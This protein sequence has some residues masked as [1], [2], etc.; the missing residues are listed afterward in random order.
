M[1]HLFEPLFALIY[2]FDCQR[3]KLPRIPDRQCGTPK[4]CLE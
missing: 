1:H 4:D 2:S 3:R